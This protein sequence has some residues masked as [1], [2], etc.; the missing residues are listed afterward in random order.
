MLPTQIRKGLRPSLQEIVIV[1]LYLSIHPG[2]HCRLEV[3]LCHHFTLKLECLGRSS[4]FLK[5]RLNTANCSKSSRQK[6]IDCPL[7]FNEDFVGTNLA[8]FARNSTN[9]GTTPDLMT[10]LTSGSF[11]LDS[12]RLHHSREEGGGNAVHSKDELAV[13][14]IVLILPTQDG[15]AGE[16]KV[17]DQSR[18]HL[19]FA[20]AHNTF[21]SNT[22]RACT[23]EM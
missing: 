9:L 13:Q 7:T 15:R 16:E 6:S 4:P 11:S 1:S 20:C 17:I 12:R 18:K 21:I 19:T 10:S 5:Y 2:V 14:S 3:S 23:S 22:T 8:S